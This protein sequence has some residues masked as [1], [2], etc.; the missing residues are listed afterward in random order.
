[1][2]RASE[3]YPIILR[4]R[5]HP[6]NCKGEFNFARSNFTQPIGAASILRHVWVGFFNETILTFLLKNGKIW[7][8]LGENHK[9][10]H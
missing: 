6:S 5:I 10:D 3:L 7:T 2:N 8:I 9:R 1:M 4:T